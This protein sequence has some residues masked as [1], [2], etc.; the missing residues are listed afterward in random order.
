MLKYIILLIIICIIYLLVTDKYIIMASNIKNKQNGHSPIIE[1]IIKY[2]KNTSIYEGILISP[3]NPILLK[4]Y[5]NVYFSFKP[6]LIK[7]LSEYIVFSRLNI[8]N[9]DR[10]NCDW[11]SIANGLFK[12]IIDSIKYHIKNNNINLLLKVNLL[13]LNI[14]IKYI[15]TTLVFRKKQITKNNIIEYINTEIGSYNKKLYNIIY[16]SA[17]IYLLVEQ[18]ELRWCPFK[19]MQKYYRN[20]NPNYVPINNKIIYEVGRILSKYETIECVFCNNVIHEKIDPKYISNVPETSP[21]WEFY[22]YII[23]N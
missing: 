2:N 12:L 3:I 19:S 18:I 6:I 14:L 16:K 22:N 5:A 1:N 4:L 11:C 21:M 20:T 9:K 15:K 13:Y 17:Y 23:N 10:A 8:S 7:P